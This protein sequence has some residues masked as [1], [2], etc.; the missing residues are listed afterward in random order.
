M[1]QLLV[2]ALLCGRF[3]I[4]VSFIINGAGAASWIMEIAPP[5]HQALLANVML[6]SLPLAGTIASIILLGIY[7]KE[8][9]WAWR[10]GLVVRMRLYDLLKSY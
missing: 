10:G 4:G 5:K 8:G 2:A 9:E 6:S 3:I 1:I 7:D